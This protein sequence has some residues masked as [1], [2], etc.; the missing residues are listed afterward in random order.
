MS[1]RDR[2]IIDLL[3]KYYEKCNYMGIPTIR[4]SE[5]L[6]LYSIAYTYL[7][8]SNNMKGYIVDAGAGAGF[9]T[10]WF[11]Y[12]VK[13]AGT[14]HVVVAIDYY[15]RNLDMFKELVEKLDINVRIET[16]AGDACQVLREYPE[17]LDILF[18]DVEKHKYIE[19]IDAAKDRIKRNGI[20]LA[21]NVIFPYT[22]VVE[23]YIKYLSEILKW[24]TTIIPTEMGI[25]VSVKLSKHGEQ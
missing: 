3:S 19:C 7:T 25:G 13:D 23:K 24:K 4:W 20:V 9:S 5:G 11:V 10:I 17:K 1:L 8:T 22:P 15:K 16:I 14:N 6:I 18:I 2:R 21:H 12:A